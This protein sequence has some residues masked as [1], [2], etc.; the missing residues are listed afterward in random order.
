MAAY[1]T[2]DWKSIP[3]IYILNGREEY[4]GSTADGRALFQTEFFDR[5]CQK[6]VSYCTVMVDG[7]H[8]YVRGSGR[9]RDEFSNT[10]ECWDTGPYL[11]WQ[12]ALN[13]RSVDLV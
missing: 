6:H 3:I 8:H 13:R 12:E 5:Y 7:C 11:T 4:K 1:Y 2:K 10:Y 9:E